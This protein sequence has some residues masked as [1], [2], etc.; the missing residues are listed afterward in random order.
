MPVYNSE[1][2]VCLG[3]D[4][5]TLGQQLLGCGEDEL[6]SHYLRVMTSKLTD[7]CNNL[8]RIEA[9]KWF[10]PPSEEDEPP[11]LVEGMCVRAALAHLPMRHACPSRPG[12]GA[13]S[14][15]QAV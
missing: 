12:P 6:R 2:S 9:E 13:G 1:V 7:W 3:V 11:D 10:M 4:V 14:L 5:S 8:V 15:R